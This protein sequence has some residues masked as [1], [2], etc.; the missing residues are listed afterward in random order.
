MQQAASVPT[1][2]KGNVGMHSI[3][4]AADRTAANVIRV[5]YLVGMFFGIWS[6]FTQQTFDGRA[7]SAVMGGVLAGALIVHEFLQTRRVIMV[8]NRFWRTA[9]E[10]R[11]QLVGQL[12]MSAIILILLL[13]F[14]GLAMWQ[15]LY[16]QTYGHMPLPIE[17]SMPIQSFILPG[18]ALAAS[19]LQDFEDDP[20]ALLRRAA[21]DMLF[22]TIKQSTKQ[23]KKRL[24]TAVKNRHN[25]APITTR[26]MQDA[27]EDDSARR[28]MLI[29]EGLAQTE[30]LQWTKQGNLYLPSAGKNSSAKTQTFD[31]QNGLLVPTGSGSPISTSKAVSELAQSG[32][33]KPTD[34]GSPK[35]GRKPRRVIKLKPID[36]A[37]QFYR[38]NPDASLT[39][40]ES[41]AKVSR[42]TANKARK[43]VQSEWG[44][45]TGTED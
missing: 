44:M 28:I 30:G 41:G 11:K 5:L 24:G 4:T 29:E 26:L 14:D 3:G 1:W 35:G 40:I 42:D 27:G 31:Y 34:G 25:L 37:K 2:K 18:F 23:W 16:Y 13:G 43:I 7:V 39:D 9:K 19:L 21:S 10:E 45:L 38:N 22:S 33:R 32:S 15:Y 20:N 12:V 8:W 6:F 36:R 17:I